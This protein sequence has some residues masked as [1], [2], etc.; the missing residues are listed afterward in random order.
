ML[1]SWTRVQ[2]LDLGLVCIAHVGD[3]RV[4]KAVKVVDIMEVIVV[5]IEEGNE[6]KRWRD[7]GVNKAG[8]ANENAPSQR[9]AAA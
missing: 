1:P 8:D 3:G 9:R 5:E 4:V 7:E 6:V 2:Y